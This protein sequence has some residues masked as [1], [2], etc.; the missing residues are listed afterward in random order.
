M[1]YEQLTPIVEELTKVLE[2]KASREDIEQQVSTFA[3]VYKVAHPV[4][5]GR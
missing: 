2:G 3:N 5:A 1:E 4:H